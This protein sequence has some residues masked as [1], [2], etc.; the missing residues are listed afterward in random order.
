VNQDDDCPFCEIAQ[1]PAH[2]RIVS[3]NNYAFLIRDGNPISAGHSLIIPKRHIGSFFKTS[4]GEKHCILELLEQAKIQLD[5]E[6][7]PATYNIG[8]N[9]GPA[10]GQTVPHMHIHVIPRYEDDEQ[11]SKGGMRCVVPT[12]V[13]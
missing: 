12:T 2:Q 9:D 7:Q 8:I 1:E 5:R 4:E 3:Q 10:A 6:F 11:E 13:D